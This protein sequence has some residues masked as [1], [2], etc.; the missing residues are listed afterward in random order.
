M[1]LYYLNRTNKDNHIYNIPPQVEQIFLP[2]NNCYVFVK[3]TF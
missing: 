1:D 2:D 3:F